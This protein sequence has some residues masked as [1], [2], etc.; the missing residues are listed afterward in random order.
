[1]SVLTAQSHYHIVSNVLD[2]TT[3]KAKARKSQ[4]QD[5]QIL[6]SRTGR[7]QFSTL[8]TVLGGFGMIEIFYVLAEVGWR[9]WE[10]GELSVSVVQL[11][12]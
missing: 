2:S 3:F 6:S 1:M 9:C 5:Q 10:L 12:H 7:G 4:G 11:R 8:R